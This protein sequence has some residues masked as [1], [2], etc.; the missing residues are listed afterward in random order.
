MMD[1]RRAPGRIEWADLFRTEMP[2]LVPVQP[3]IFFKR[4]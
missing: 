4:V 1:S 3:A 2:A